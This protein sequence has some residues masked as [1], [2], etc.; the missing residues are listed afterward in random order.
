MQQVGARSLR[1]PKR[2]RR[3]PLDIATTKAFL[4]ANG[5]L[6]EEDTWLQ[7]SLLNVCELRNHPAGSFTHHVGDPSGGIYGIVSGGIG[8]LLPSRSL[9]LMLCHILRPGIWFGHGPIL[10]G[11]SRSLAFQAIEPSVSAYVPYASL[12]K[13]TTERPE[14][15]L[16]LAALSERNFTFAIS[17]IGDLM[18]P[19]SERRIAA[20]LSRISR[21][22]TGSQ[23]QPHPIRLSQSLL[24]QMANA[25]RDRV[26]AALSKFAKKGWITV[27]FKLIEVTDLAAL[28]D[29]A[30]GQQ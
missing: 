12:Q 28:E 19:S 24:G 6:A 5:W 10:T 22:A 2:E 18:I 13:L 9:E 27:S 11:K 7:N 25:S 17:T 3:H 16:R 20:V 1:S 8:V 26:N 21:P 14:V 23:K 29:Y 30:A 4:L 15:R